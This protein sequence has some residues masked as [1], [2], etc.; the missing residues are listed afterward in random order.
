MGGVKGISKFYFKRYAKFE[1]ENPYFTLKIL[2]KKNMKKV[3]ISYI[4]SIDKVNL[5]T[6]FLNKTRKVADI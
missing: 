2:M 1:I 5:G 6:T 4:E 3:I